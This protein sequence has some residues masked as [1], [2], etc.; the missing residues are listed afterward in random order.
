MG[1]RFDDCY[2]ARGVWSWGFVKDCKGFSPAPLTDKS[3]SA[4]AVGHF[5]CTNLKLVGEFGMI[6]S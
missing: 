4:I 5:C 6:Q 1:R 2:E 3:P